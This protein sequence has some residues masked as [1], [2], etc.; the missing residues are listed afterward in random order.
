MTSLFDDLTWRGLIQQSTGSG[1][2]LRAVLDGPPITF[3][4]G[5]DP[6]APSLHIGNLVQLLTARR[7]QHG[8]HVPLGLVGGSTGL[9]GD[10]RMSGERV[11]N[12]PEVVAGWVEKI[13]VQVE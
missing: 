2:A 6:T 5:F 4:V 8:G 13:R 7:I 9:I 11:L 3:Y 12:S 10:P 1:D